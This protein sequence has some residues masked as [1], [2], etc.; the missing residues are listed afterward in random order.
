MA[1]FN[2][3]YIENV[4]LKLV[5]EKAD[6]EKSGHVLEAYFHLSMLPSPFLTPCALLLPVSHLTPTNGLVV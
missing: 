5:L 4:I 3:G 2:L 6:S 1:K